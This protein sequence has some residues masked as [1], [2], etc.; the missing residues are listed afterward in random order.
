MSILLQDSQYRLL[1]QLHQTEINH[2]ISAVLNSFNAISY[3]LDD[4]DSKF[5]NINRN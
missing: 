1:K 3:G 5:E 4:I 2:A